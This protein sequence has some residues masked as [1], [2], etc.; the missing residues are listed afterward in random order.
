VNAYARL[1]RCFQPALSLIR[2]VSG[3]SSALGRLT[4]MRRTDL[5]RQ[6]PAATRLLPSA[7]FPLAARNR[8]AAQLAAGPAWPGTGTSA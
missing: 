8:Q 1:C 5:T 7:R 3:G 2:A 6:S 4:T